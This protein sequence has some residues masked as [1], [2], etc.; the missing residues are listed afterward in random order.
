[1]FSEYFEDWEVKPKY[2]KEFLSL[3]EGWLGKENYHKLNEVTE[4]EWA[5]FN[6]LLRTLAKEFPI[7]LVDCENKLLTSI[8]DIESVL[9]NYEDSMGNNSTIFTKLVIPE[10]GCVISEEWDYTYVI[11]HK[12]NG[13]MEKLSPIIKSAGL[14]HFHD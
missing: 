14:K 4:D 13:A 3:W 10:L 7:E 12:K 8:H 11:W 9:S 2:S 1:M 5:R 6:G